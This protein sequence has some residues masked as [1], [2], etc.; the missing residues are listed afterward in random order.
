MRNKN[1]G[2]G[3]EARGQVVGLEWEREYY[4]QI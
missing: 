1:R 3:S 4:S 2:Q